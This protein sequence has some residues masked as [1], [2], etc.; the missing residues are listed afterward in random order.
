MRLVLSKRPPSKI[1][2]SAWTIVLVALFL[3]LFLLWLAHHHEDPAHR[4][5]ETI[6]MESLMIARALVL[7]NG[8]ANPFPGYEAT[9]AWLAPA[10]PWLASIGV[11]LSN[12]DGYKSVLF[13]QV[14]NSIFSALTCWPIYDLG[15]RIFTAKTGR[16]AAWLWVFLPS[17]ILM[18]LEWTWDQSLSALLVGCVLS[19]TFG[20]RRSSAYLS[21]A[22]YGIL[23]GAAALT[24]PSIC[25][26]LPFLGLWLMLDR[27]KNTLAWKMPLATA[28]IVFLLVLLPWTLRNQT[29]LGKYFFV[30]SNFGLALWLGNNPESKEIYSP[31]QYPA[32]NTRELQELQAL[33]EVGYMKLKQRE[34]VNFI[35]ANPGSFISRCYYRFVDTW[36][37]NYDSTLDP[38]IR[39]MQLR[40]PYIEYLTLFSALAFA[41][42]GIALLTVAWDALPLAFCVVLF[43]IPYYLTTSELRYRHPID[44]VLV[45]LA[46]VCLERLGEIF[47]TLR[48]VEP[49]EAKP[50]LGAQVPA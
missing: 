19:A 43:P 38:Y 18:P 17:A 32:V 41:G 40:L 12:I 24:N 49:V 48:E 46:L 33:G 2:Q 47:L 7:G 30:K 16:A 44:P 45:I 42:L 1:L 5:L 21:W 50:N 26:L 6:G 39:K 22:G 8:F 14:L 29:Q 13:C 31:N 25:V 10:Y 35:R 11:R 36:T 4:R 28:A 23:W 27:R 37:G 20:L 15:K 34:A 9:T 3:R